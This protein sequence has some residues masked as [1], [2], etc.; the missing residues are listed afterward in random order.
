V[1]I[2]I[3]T[4]KAAFAAFLVVPRVLELLTEGLII[5]LISM[6]FNFLKNKFFYIALGILVILFINFY[7]EG[8]YRKK[9]KNFFYS[10]SSSLQTTFWQAGIK[11]S[12]FFKTISDIKNLKKENE[13]LKLKNE[14]LLSKVSDLENLKKENQALRD[15]LGLGLEK[16]FNLVMARVVSKDISRDEIEINKGSK[17]GI[18]KDLP[19]I[20]SQKIV[21][22]KISE[23][24][25]N[26][27]KVM[28]IS[29][30]NSSFSA[31]IAGKET[32]GVVKGNGSSDAFFDLVPKED[33][34]LP[35]DLV[36]TSILG[37]IFP[38]GLLIGEIKNVK[39][40]DIDPFQQAAISL[41]SNISDLDQ[42]FVIVNF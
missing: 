13:E 18:S 32:T 12:Y 34:I 30:K 31:K 26:F 5:Y 25:D 3:T 41:F 38:E 9:L 36:I 10:I 16:D 19:V 28:L 11:V 24:Y 17:D 2:E 27:S 4:R 33:E 14:E 8:L 7:Q 1:Q 22:G 6:R 23:V 39:K 35:G 37:N 15:A 21:I 29:D 20:T 40:S 42:L